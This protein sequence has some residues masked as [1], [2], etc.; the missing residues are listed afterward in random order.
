MKENI[1]EIIEKYELKSGSHTSL[2]KG[3]CIMELV[4]YIANEPW[5]DHPQCACPILTRFAIRYNDRVDHKQRQKMKEIIPLLLNSRNKAM[6]VKRTRFFGLKA[7]TVFLPTLT[8]AL[9]LP[10]ITAK[11]R[12]FTVDQF[13]EARDYINSVRPQ[14]KEAARKRAYADADAAADAAAYAATTATVAAYAA[15]DAAAT[16]TV[17]AYAAAYAAADAPKNKKFWLDL[18]QKLWDHGIEALHEACEL[19]DT[20]QES[21]KD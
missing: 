21:G 17:A 4:S 6:E 7:V 10:E 11:L 18:K 14:I 8:E 5:S 1:R 16:A 15:A 19:K 2:E 12:L 9:D 13:L 3:A 20:D